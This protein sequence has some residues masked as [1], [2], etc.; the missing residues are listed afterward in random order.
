MWQLT[1]SSSEENG[2]LIVRYMFMYNTSAEQ[3]H[4]RGLIIWGPK[5]TV[6]AHSYTQ[7]WDWGGLDLLKG[8]RSPVK[9]QEDFSRATGKGSILTHLYRDTDKICTSDRLFG[10]WHIGWI[11][12][13][14]VKSDLTNSHLTCLSGAFQECLSLVNISVHCM[15][16]SSLSVPCKK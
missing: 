11:S 5:F 7:H 1:H 12:L 10:F 13:Y 16:M 2:I 6:Q 4:S 9:C 8:Y 14:F 15:G 3:L